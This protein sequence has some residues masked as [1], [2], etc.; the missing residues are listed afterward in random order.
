MGGQAF[1]HPQRASAGRPVVDAPQPQQVEKDGQKD[2]QEATG[3]QIVVVDEGHS[4]PVCMAS[5]EHLLPDVSVAETNRKDNEKGARQGLLFLAFL[6]FR[7]GDGKPKV[8]SLS[9]TLLTLRQ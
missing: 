3:E 7:P 8:G 2:D 5:S 4:P 6:T 9:T 1:L